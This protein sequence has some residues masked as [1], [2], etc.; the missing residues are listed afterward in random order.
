M[1]TRG[2]IS[3]NNWFHWQPYL[4]CSGSRTPSIILLIMEVEKMLSEGFRQYLIDSKSI[5]HRVDKTSHHQWNK[6]NSSE[7]WYQIIIDPI[8]Q[9]RRRDWCYPYNIIHIL[10]GKFVCIK[11][12]YWNHKSK[13]LCKLI[14][15]FPLMIN[16][17]KHTCPWS[18]MIGIS[19]S[20]W[21]FSRPYKSASVKHTYIW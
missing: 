18:D 21:C 2:P 12:K 5:H 1:K 10:H 16:V 7:K 6:R 14:M 20:L 4:A 15:Q 8:H 3:L 9:Y 19:S 11:A 13:V 17:F